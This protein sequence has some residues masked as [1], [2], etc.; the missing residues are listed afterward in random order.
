MSEVTVFT[1]SRRNTIPP[2]PPTHPA[3]ITST[4]EYCPCSFVNVSR[5]LEQLKQK[6]PAVLVFALGLLE[7]GYTGSPGEPPSVPPMADKG[8]HSS[9]QYPPSSQLSIWLICE[10]GGRKTFDNWQHGGHPSFCNQLGRRTGAGSPGQP[11]ILLVMR[12]VCGMVG[13]SPGAGS[14]PA[15]CII[16]RVVLSLIP[17]LDAFVRFVFSFLA[18]RLVWMVTCVLR[19]VVRLGQVFCVFR[20]LLF[21]L[22]NETRQE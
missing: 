21:C 16:Q 18:G 14:W 4:H 17:L 20:Y 19:G 6:Q 15:A 22:R 11:G 5:S 13:G 12:A 1:S 3:T 2:G 8:I 10:G 7:I 9:S